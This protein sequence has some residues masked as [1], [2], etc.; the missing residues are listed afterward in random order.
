AQL[1]ALALPA[2]EV[3]DLYP[4]SPMQQGMLFH[5]LEGAAE[6]ETPYVTQLAVDVEG[7]EEERFAAAW[8]WVTA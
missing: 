5:A 2:R 4:L 8:G 6:G 1:D 3:E 7:V